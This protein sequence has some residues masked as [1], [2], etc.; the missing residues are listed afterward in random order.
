MT[1]N[2]KPNKTI[3]TIPE[4]LD[5]TNSLQAEDTWAIPLDEV[6]GKKKKIKIED[7]IELRNKGLSFQ[8]I[9]DILKCSKANVHQ[10]LQ[11]Y[12]DFEGFAK[13]TAL[14]YET[15]QY[16]IYNAI[17]DGTIEK[18][19]LQSKVW[20][21]AVLEDKK[22]LIRNQTTAI[23]DIDHTIGSIADLSSREKIL[24]ARYR[25]LTGKE[26]RTDTNK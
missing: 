8:Q 6:I 7:I 17:D 23:I 4:P 24:E 22:R 13:D 3:K 16:K 2:I 26:L 9:A 5:S 14:R 15:L 18:A 11:D 25:L 12:K 20:A 10:R 1:K 19:N 21:L